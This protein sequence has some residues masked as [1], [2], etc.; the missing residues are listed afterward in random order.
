MSFIS[1]FVSRSFI[2]R[3]CIY[4]ANMGLKSYIYTPQVGS[5][6]KSYIYASDM[7]LTTSIGLVYNSC[8]YAPDVNLISDLYNANLL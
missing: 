2:L 7:I 3:S 8:I 5:V 1:K 6:P 4:T